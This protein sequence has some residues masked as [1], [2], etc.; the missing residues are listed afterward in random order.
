MLGS[1]RCENRTTIESNVKIRLRAERRVRL[2][3][4][5]WRIVRKHKAPIGLPL[6]LDVEGQRGSF[7]HRNAKESLLSWMLGCSTCTIIDMFYDGRF[8]L[9]MHLY[10]RSSLH[11]CE[12]QEGFL[13]I[14]TPTRRK[15]R[16]EFTILLLSH[17][18]KS[19]FHT[20]FAFASVVYVCAWVCLSPIPSP[21]H[22]HHAR[23]EPPL[24]T[25]CASI[26]LLLLAFR[27][28]EARVWPRT[29]RPCRQMRR[30]LRFGREIDPPRR[31]SSLVRGVPCPCDFEWQ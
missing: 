20:S 23:H 11:I 26:H 10:C 7:L 6:G 9:M 31:W 16:W 13:A 17:T 27:R 12:C 2:G 4:P 29:T 1:R 18:C 5:P 3:G 24:T 30:R 15:L 14:L 19:T 22:G 8:M 28:G 25:T 21:R